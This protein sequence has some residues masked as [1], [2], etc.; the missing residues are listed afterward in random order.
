MVTRTLG[1]KPLSWPFKLVG[2]LF[3]GIMVLGVVAFAAIVGSGMYYEL[4]RTTEGDVEGMIE[5]RMVT[6][7][8]S[9]DR[10]IAFLDARSI[11]HGP[12]SPVDVADPRLKN[13]DVPEG[14]T[15]VSAVVRN[16]GY[17]LELVDVGVMF[18]FDARGTLADWVVWEVKR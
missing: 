4:T 7:A 13:A 17:A 16:D 11:E 8:S 1:R 9:T 12:V 6:G 10:V 18:I 2:W 3:L 14:A 15:T 5:E